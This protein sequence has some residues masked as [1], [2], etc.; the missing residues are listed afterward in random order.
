MTIQDDLTDAEV[1]AIEKFNADEVMSEAVKKVLL[2]S[3]YKQGTVK[4]GK[5]VDTTMN[6]ALVLASI[7]C[8]GTSV[9]SDEALGQDLRGL[10]RGVQ[11]VQTGF[12]DLE[13]I[14][15]ATLELPIEKINEAI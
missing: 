9:I 15:T 10:W 3:V 6:A 4:K 11:L 2:N 13:K 7:A 5:K 12:K 8:S 14:K 1:L